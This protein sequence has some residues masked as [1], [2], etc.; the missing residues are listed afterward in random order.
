MHK[1]LPGER[2]VFNGRR[3]IAVQFCKRHP[4][5]NP[6]RWCALNRLKSNRTG[7][8]C[9]GLQCVGDRRN[10]RLVI[11]VTDTP[12]NRRLFRRNPRMT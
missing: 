9:F 6:C 4:R 12:A 11:F 1:C 2:A 7:V 8:L 5:C 3:Y 10:R